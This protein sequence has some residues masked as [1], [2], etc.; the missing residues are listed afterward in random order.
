M[1]NEVNLGLAGFCHDLDRRNAHDVVLLLSW[2]APWFPLQWS[3]YWHFIFQVSDRPR[4]CCVMPLCGLDTRLCL[5]LFLQ[6]RLASWRISLRLNIFYVLRFVFLLVRWGERDMHALIIIFFSWQEGTFGTGRVAIRTNWVHS[7]DVV[8]TNWTTWR[9]WAAGM[10]SSSLFW[11]LVHLFFCAVTWLHASRSGGPVF[12]C[13]RGLFW[14]CPSIQVQAFLEPLSG[15]AM[16]TEIP[17]WG[18][19][20]LESVLVW[21]SLLPLSVH[22]CL[23]PRPA[24]QL[25][26]RKSHILYLA[27]TA[28]FS[29]PSRALIMRSSK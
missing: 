14:F 21:P 24:P 6:P 25:P 8:W 2:P 1:T 16:P 7:L 28:F 12:P 11:T 4:L 23:S 15:L 9:I 5:P 3:H 26:S 27:I 22:D 29:I 10:G 20:W 19:F 18:S 17:R 13:P